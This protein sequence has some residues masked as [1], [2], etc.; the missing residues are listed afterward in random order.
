MEECSPRTS[1]IRVMLSIEEFAAVQPGSLAGR[2]MAELREPNRTC[3]GLLGSCRRVEAKGAGSYASNFTH[4][5]GR[6]VELAW[7]V[8]REDDVFAHDELNDRASLG[9]G[10]FSRHSARATHYLR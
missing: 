9:L 10:D 7:L 8:E 3:T 4:R 6:T 5:N 2:N 1:I